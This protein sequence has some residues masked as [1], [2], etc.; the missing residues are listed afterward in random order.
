MKNNTWAAAEA[1]LPPSQFWID[2]GNFV[3][4]SVHLDDTDKYWE[5]LVHW[6]DILGKRYNNKIANYVIMDYLDGQSR[7]ATGGKR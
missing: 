7:R 3:N 5:T 4:A 2:F 1:D 6:G